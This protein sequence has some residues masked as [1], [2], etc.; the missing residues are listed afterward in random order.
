[1]TKEAILKT[2]HA[3]PFRPFSLRL[4][5]GLLLRVPHPDFITVTQGGRTAIVLGEGEDFSIIDLALVT[6]IETAASNAA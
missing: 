4:T 3:N 2:V 1:M 6:A 5:D